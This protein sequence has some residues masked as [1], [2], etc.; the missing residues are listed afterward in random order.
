MYPAE[1]V[2]NRFQGKLYASRRQQSNL[3]LSSEVEDAWNW[4]ISSTGLLQYITLPM[5]ETL[6]MPDHVPIQL[7]IMQR[8]IQRFDCRIQNLCCYIDETPLLLFFEL[9]PALS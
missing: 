3:H 6:I 8:F 9:M 4:L 7:L 2:S 1:T 5:L